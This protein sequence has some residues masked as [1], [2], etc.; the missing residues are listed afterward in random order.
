M[1]KDLE[2]Y[3]KVVKVPPLRYRKRSWEHGN[4]PKFPVIKINFKELK[5]RLEKGE[6]L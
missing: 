6:D 5:K 1:R 2:K 4:N 3:V